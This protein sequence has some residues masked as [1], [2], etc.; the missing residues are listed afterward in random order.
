S[1]FAC[2]GGGC[3]LCKETGWIEILGCGMVH[4]SVLRTAQIDPEKNSGFA[5]GMG[6]ERIAMLRYGV[7]D[8]RL[9]YENDCRFLGQF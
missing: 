8:I 4:P 7:P 6:V 5:I 3:R 2:D 9:F 1:C